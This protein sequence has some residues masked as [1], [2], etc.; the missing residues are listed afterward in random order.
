MNLL[1]KVRMTCSGIALSAKRISELTGNRQICIILDMLWCLIRYGA[2]P[3]NYELFDFYTLTPE[4]RKTYVTYAVSRKMI[5]KFNDPEKIGLFENKIS[6]A[7]TF[8]DLY[9]RA[10]LDTSDMSLREFETFCQ[11]KTKIICKPVAGSQGA[12]IRVYHL[13]DPAE[14]YR[15]IQTNYAKGFILEEWIPQHEV[16]SDIYPDAVNCLRIITLLDG[17]AVHLLAGGVT[18]ATET[19]IANGSQPS[20]IAPV[21]FETGMIHKPAATFD[22]GPYERHPK[23]NAQ[24][25]GV[26]LPYW[27]ETRKMLEQACRRVPSVRY[28]GWDIAFTPT[29]PILIEGNTTPGYKYYQIPQH[30]E[31]GVGNRRKYERHR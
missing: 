11:G 15:D 26:Q 10:F 30:L 4:K 16:L 7:R 19:E 12:D 3:N 31:N 25:L 28:V 2:S 24:I 29:G 22:G 17:D 27:Q 6:F 1:A 21:D 14:I 5:K 13:H 9:R 23:T 8:S 20:I 18:F